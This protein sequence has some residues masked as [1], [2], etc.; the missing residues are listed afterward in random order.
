LVA[1]PT[2]G[3]AVARGLLPVGH[4]R[5]DLT[6]PAG[7]LAPPTAPTP[8]RQPP[9]PPPHTAALTPPPHPARHLAEAAVAR[10]T[11]LGLALT[12]ADL[13]G[14]MRG[15]VHLSAEYA[16]ERRQYGQPIGSFPAVP[17]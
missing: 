10:W 7:A 13:V 8:L 4:A 14:T 6:R 9:A 1:T 12:S 11:A 17:A 15:A 2:G 5:V 3:Q 16:K